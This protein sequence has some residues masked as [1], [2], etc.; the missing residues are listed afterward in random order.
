M[1]KSTSNACIKLRDKNKNA[2]NKKI[3][4]SKLSKF[5]ATKDGQVKPIR[6]STWVVLLLTWMQMREKQR[7]LASWTWEQKSR[8][9]CL[10]QSVDMFTTD[11]AQ[12]RL[13]A[14]QTNC[15]RLVSFKIGWVTHLD[16]FEL[17][18]ENDHEFATVC[19][20]LCHMEDKQVSR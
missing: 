13:F 5:D 9:E 14:S 18:S 10:R 17:T 6:L 7:I 3:N 12:A 20:A 15:V 19:P 8:T 4:C 11:M 1:D 2:K 16:W